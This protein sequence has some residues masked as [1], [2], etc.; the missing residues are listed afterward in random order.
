LVSRLTIKSAT[1]VFDWEN[2]Y[3][4]LK[5]TFN[6]TDIEVV[7]NALVQKLRSSDLALCS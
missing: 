4:E 5:L 6:E 1:L 2:G 3:N 7:T